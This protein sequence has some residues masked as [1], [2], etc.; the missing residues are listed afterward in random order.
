MWRFYRRNKT[1][2]LYNCYFAINRD[3]LILLCV[4]CLYTLL[5]AVSYYDSNVLSMS[6]IGFPNK[7]L[8]WG[9]MGGVSSIQFF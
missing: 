9:W 5:K 7:S 4:L 1:Q 2:S 8:D 3:L 6:V